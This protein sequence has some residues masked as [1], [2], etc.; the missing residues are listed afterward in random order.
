MCHLPVAARLL[1]SHKAL[2][3]C[4]RFNPKC[5]LHQ[6]HRWWALQPLSVTLP[7]CLLHHRSRHPHLLKRTTFRRCSAPPTS[8]AQHS[9]RPRAP[10][11]WTV[12]APTGTS[13][14][15]QLSHPSPP[16]SASPRKSRSVPLCRVISRPFPRALRC[17]WSPP[18][19]PRPSTA[20][21]RAP[22]RLPFFRLTPTWTIPILPITSSHRKGFFQ[23]KTPTLLDV[24]A[25]WT[26]YFFE[27]SATTF[28]VSRVFVLLSFDLRTILTS[29]CPGVGILE[30]IFFLRWPFSNIYKSTK[31]NCGTTNTTELYTFVKICIHSVSIIWNPM[32]LYKMH[33]QNIHQYREWLYTM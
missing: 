8:R 29:D 22:T 33:I 21:L 20:Q 18:P 10:A 26:V 6:G 5:P 12:A 3:L 24:F 16:A 2:I 32:C 25:S 17:S 11:P 19:A 14:S 4:H 9:P 30:T 7:A 13:T 31:W 28:F 27:M 15:H 23:S 1:N